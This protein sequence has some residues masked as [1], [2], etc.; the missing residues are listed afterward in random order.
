M[1]LLLFIINS[2]GTTIITTA[3]NARAVVGYAM[4]GVLLV[5]RGRSRNLLPYDAAGVQVGLWSA[6]QGKAAN[7]VRVTQA[8]NVALH[9]SGKG[10][11]TS[12][13]RGTGLQRIEA[14]RR[15]AKHAAKCEAA[16]LGLPHLMS[17]EDELA[18][19]A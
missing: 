2:A 17:R 5:H 8:G 15:K 1:V 3:S 4:P 14:T 6:M 13:D 16:A 11:M 10:C 9:V 18:D 7:L 19:L 12:E